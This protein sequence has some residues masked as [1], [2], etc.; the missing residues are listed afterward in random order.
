MG[1]VCGVV[2][3]LSV[4][5]GG[6]TG[7]AARCGEKPG[8]AAAV[9]AAES[10]LTA[11]CGCCGPASQ[12]R[13]CVAAVV[14]Q[15]VR[16]RSLASTCKGKVK[17]D[18]LVAC[19]LATA[20]TPC[21]GCSSDAQC[22]DGNPCTVDRCVDGTCEHGC[23]CVTPGSDLGCCGPGP[24]CVTTTTTT[25]STTTTLPPPPCHTDA[26]CD[27][28]NPCTADRCVNGMCEH[29]CVCLDGTGAV[30]CCPGPAALCV[31]PCGMDANGVC[32][33]VCPAANE[34]CTASGTTCAC[35]PIPPSCGADAAGVCGGTCPTGATCESLPTAATPTCRC[36]SG[37]GGPCGGFVFPPPPVCAPGL[38]CQQTNP[39][40]PGVCVNPT[41]VPF[42]ANGC[43]Q[44]SDCC[45]PC[46][47]L[48]RAPCAVCLQGQCVGTP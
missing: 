23:V 16:A 8:D 25:S 48:Q 36:V 15:A 13:R 3:A 45:E 20:A 17:R 21:T 6:A 37:L 40:V 31:R 30:S 38:V 24:L 47:V 41:C 22:D 19:P 28:G 1:Q 9:A 34:V 10:V 11:Q 5:L 2:V 7:A 32:G 42:S 35:T 4:L 43:T 39:D 44:T 27:D 33:G 14:R 26:D 29:A 18:A 46:T 12:Y